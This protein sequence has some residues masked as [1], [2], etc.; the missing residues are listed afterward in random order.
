M[1]YS[2]IISRWRWEIIIFLYIGKLIIA[3]FKGLS[4]LEKGTIFQQV[5]GISADSEH[6]RQLH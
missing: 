3:R 1:T 4:I 6:Q 2:A 5:Q